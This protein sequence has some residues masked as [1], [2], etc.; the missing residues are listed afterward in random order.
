M[1]SVS[2]KLTSCIL[3]NIIPTTT[4]INEVKINTNII[5]LITFPTLLGDFNLPIL[6]EIVKNISGTIIT[7]SIFINKSPNGFKKQIF[8]LKTNPK[9][10][11]IKINN[12]KINEFL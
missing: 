12:N 5:L 2:F 4:L 11:P 9:I 1:L 3:L 8:S 10:V 6:V 7:I